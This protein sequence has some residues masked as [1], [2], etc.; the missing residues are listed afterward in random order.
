MNID[1]GRKAI[2][3]ATEKLRNWGRWGKDDQIGTL[4]HVDAGGH[5]AGGRIDPHRQGVRARHAARPPRPA[6]R[7]VGRALESDPHDAGDRH[8]CGGGPLRQDAGHPLRDDAIN[9]PVQSATHWDS[10]GHI[11]YDDKMYN[12]F[13]AREADSNGLRQARHRAHQEQDG[14][15]RRAARHRPLPRR[16]TGSRTA[17]PSPM[18]SS[19]NAPR[20]PERRDQARRFRHPAH[21]ADGALPQGEEVGRLCRRRRARREVRELLLV[22]GQERSRRSAPTPGAS[23][24]GRTRPRRSA[25][26]GTG[27]SS[28]RWG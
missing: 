23:R 20:K 4:N 14:R 25:S 17:R 19:T 18:A 16:S 27:W 22:P 13:D 9:M 28:R 2:A 24:C 21:R 12:G 15:P 11:F 3:E 10:L 26:P 5:R 8:R 6:I 1:V 7:A